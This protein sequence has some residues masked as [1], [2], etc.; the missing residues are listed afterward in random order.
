M[1]GAAMH[2]SNQRRFLAR[3]KEALGNP[4]GRPDPFAPDPSLSPEA[5]LRKINGRTPKDYESLI[6]TLESAAGPLNLNVS[7]V[8]DVDAAGQTLAALVR[9]KETEWGDEKSLVAW[10]HPLVDRL[11]IEKRLSHDG[12]PVYVAGL[13]EGAEEDAGRVLFRE[14]VEAAY[15][16]VTSAD[17]CVVDTATLVMKTR[18]GHG[19]SV[20]LVPSIHV[21]VIGMT[22]LLADLS[23]LY[24]LI[25]SDPAYAVEGLTHCMTF[26]SGPSKTADIEATLVHGAHGPKEVHI[27]VIK[28]LD[29]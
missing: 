6:R 20:S 18:P 22:Q 13:G 3:V 24:T 26:I 8:E 16:G 17:F 27:I 28:T 2:H 4:A 5:I 14:R 10:E 15:I 21:A 7:T 12:V 9:D 11:D 1:K 25:Q 19:R 23:E 29:T